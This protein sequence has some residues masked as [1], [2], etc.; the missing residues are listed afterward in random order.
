MVNNVCAA[1]RQ[2]VNAVLSRQH[3]ICQWKLVSDVMPEPRKIFRIEERAASRLGAQSTDAQA[4]L[5][6]AELMQEIAALRA[7]LAAMAQPPSDG[8][9]APRNGAHAR[10]T[11]ELNLIAGAIG[12]ETAHSVAAGPAPAMPPMTRIAHELEEGED[13]EE[14]G[15]GE[16][17]D[18]EVGGILAHD[19]VVEQER[20]LDA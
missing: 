8:A 11:C 1:E 20:E 6:H 5:R 15:E 16:V 2:A 17:D 14:G 13:E 4:P 7:M 12:G 3:V 9:G 19:V 10:L 18:G